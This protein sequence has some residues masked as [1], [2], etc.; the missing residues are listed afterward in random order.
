MLIFSLQVCTNEKVKRL[1]N[2][3]NTLCNSFK[4]IVC[5]TKS[6]PEITENKVCED[7]E[8]VVSIYHKIMIPNLN[9]YSVT[10]SLR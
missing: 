9:I 1:A 8:K 6:C 7:V 10:S 2:I 3:P 4:K 5:I